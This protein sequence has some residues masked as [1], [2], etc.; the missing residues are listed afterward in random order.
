MFI[1]MLIVLEVFNMLV[2]VVSRNCCNG[3]ASACVL[4]CAEY[5]REL[6]WSEIL[7]KVINV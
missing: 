3:R 4:Y 6:R 7:I 2:D 1:N 5:F